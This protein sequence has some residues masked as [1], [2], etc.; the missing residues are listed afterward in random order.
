MATAK[1]VELDETNTCKICDNALAK[2]SCPKCNLLYCS[3]NCYQSNSHLE[4]SESFYKDNILTELSLDKND[5]ESQKKMLEI[6]EGTHRNNQIAFSEDGD[7]EEDYPNLNFE[8]IPNLDS[9]DDEI[10]L[11]IGDRLAGV[12]LDDAEQVWVKLTEDEKQEFVSFLKSEDVTKLIPPWQPWWLYYADTKVE[13]MSLKE[14]YKNKCPVICDIKSFSQMKTKIPADCVKYNL[15]NII[16]AYAFTA[17]YFNGEHFDF[18]K[19]AVSCMVNISLT[20][21][22]SQNFEDFETAVKSVEQ[23]CIN[24]DWIVSDSENILT[25]RD[26]LEKIINGPK[27][28]DSKYYLLCALSDI[29]HLLEKAVKPTEASNSKV[30]TKQFPNDHFP[31]VKLEDAKSIKSHSKK[32]EYFLSYAKDCFTFP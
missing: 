2:Y 17:R 18:S 6:L 7:S 23:E 19:E 5:V 29:L 26:D 28:S 9:D 25:M 27:K 24:S 21:K 14:T 11:D 8:D 16:A 12:D 10:Y 13:D 20:L 3:L 4:C 30:F 1:I 31:D 22:S 15:I 32:I